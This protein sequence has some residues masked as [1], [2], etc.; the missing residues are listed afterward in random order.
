MRC[1]CVDEP[2]NHFLRPLALMPSHH[3]TAAVEQ[4]GGGF[5]T[6]IGLSIYMYLGMQ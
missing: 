3:A 5:S 1:C 2:G 4:E 6:H